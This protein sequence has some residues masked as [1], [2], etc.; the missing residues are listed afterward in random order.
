MGHRPENR[1]TETER[2]WKVDK[3]QNKNKIKMISRLTKR[4]KN[5][6][7]TRVKTKPT[8]QAQHR[9]GK[10]TLDFYNIISEPFKS[11]SY[12]STAPKR[13]TEQLWKHEMIV[14]TG[15]CTVSQL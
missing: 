7:G 15:W 3:G 14:V 8:L 11:R 9:H 2:K 10:A 12:T 4:M 5:W 6:E 1:V 13:S